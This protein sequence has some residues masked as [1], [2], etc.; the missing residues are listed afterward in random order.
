MSSSICSS[1]KNCESSSSVTVLSVVSELM[2][3]AES[4]E[5]SADAKRA[6]ADGAVEDT[7]VP[8]GIVS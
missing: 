6:S 7:S 1:S 5:P 8:S 2:E 4:E 3:F